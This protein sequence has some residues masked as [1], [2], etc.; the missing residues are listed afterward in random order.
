[1][2]MWGA[3]AAHAADAGAEALASGPLTGSLAAASSDIVGEGV[4]QVILGATLVFLS[5]ST[6]LTLIRIVRGPTVL[7][8]AIGSEVLVAIVIC[9]LGVE[10]AFYRHTTTLPLLLSLSMLGFLGSVAVARFVPRDV[11]PGGNPLA[12]MP[13]PEDPEASRRLGRQAEQDR[14]VQP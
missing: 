5:V 3:L 13:A 12:G 4:Q 14:E 11:D 8:R 9:A 10:A 2:T 1:M 6:L 7:D